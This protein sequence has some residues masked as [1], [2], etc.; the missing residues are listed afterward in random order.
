M[1]LSNLQPAKV[2]EYFEELCQI[3]HGSGNVQ[4]I[5]DYCVDFAKKHNLKYRQDDK[6]NVVIFKDAAKGYED[7]KPV[8]LQGH[9][10]MVAVK[11]EDCTLDMESQGLDI[12]VDGDFIKAH[13]TTLGA[14]DG[15]AVAYALAILADDNIEHPAIEAVFTVDEEIG[16]L[17]ATA[18]DLSDLKSNT[19]LNIDS[20]DEGVFLAGC[21]G[22]ATLRIKIPVKRKKFSG[23][24]M[25]IKLS[26]LKG[27]HSGTEIITQR[28]NANV[29][30]GRVLN[31][32][33]K[34][35]DYN[36]MDIFG[37]E[38][39]NAISV[40][41][42]TKVVVS[43]D[44]KS[45]IIN[46]VAELNEVLKKEYE[47]TD[48]DLLLSVEACGENKEYDVFDDDSLENVRLALNILPSGV[49]KMSNDIKGLVQTSLNLG[50][51]KTDTDYVELCYLVR[52]SLESEKEFLI[53]KISDFTKY[54]GGSISISG[55]Y[56]AWE[57]KSKSPLRDLFV[58]CFE[59]MYG[60]KP[61]VETIHAGVECGIIA[62]KIK[63][64]DCISFGPDIFDI[65]TTKER[66][67]ISSVERTWKLILEV[68]KQMKTKLK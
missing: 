18:I 68:F 30:A 4:K 59:D 66:L 31:K 55:N 47:V 54:I 22:G 12:Y 38:K 46:S 23:S 63:D 14:D 29:L 19:M 3:P 24:V 34:T 28:A 67:S 53:E 36:V 32:L 61:V 57:Y 40:S 5:S 37:G 43:E 48:S 26:G 60:K 45:Q 16:M 17:G 10:D 21:A 1:I 58:Q 64:L 33:S 41:S 27:G 56:P 20:E 39:D 6:Y 50:V 62:G 7:V 9:L 65:H 8:I 52:S 13:Q 11:E 49:Q 44:E 35:C 42:K 51:L 25:E 15:I 2:F